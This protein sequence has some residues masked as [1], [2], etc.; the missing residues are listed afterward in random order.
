[1]GERELRIA[2]QQVFNQVAAMAQA[3]QDAALDEV[4]SDH[5]PLQL[6]EHQTKLCVD[7]G[8]FF[9]AWAN[10]GVKVEGAGG[11]TAVVLRIAIEM[12]TFF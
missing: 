2:G 3:Y 11:M 8:M 7:L 1:M 4:H 6:F 10:A 5:S 9:F 12:L